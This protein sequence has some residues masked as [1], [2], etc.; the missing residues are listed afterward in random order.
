MKTNA[1]YFFGFFVTL[2]VLIGLSILSG[3]KAGKKSSSFTG[4]GDSS[5]A[6]VAGAI[7]GTLVGGSSTVGTAQLAYNYGLSAW[8]FTLGG[9]IGCL[10]MALWFVVPLRKKCSGTL[11]GLIAEEYGPRVGFAATI[12]SS[13]GIYINIIAQLI[14]STAVIAIVIPGVNSFLAALLAALLMTLYV[15]FG[16]V[17]G[18]GIVGILKTILLYVA[19]I[20]GGIIALKLFG[21]IRP[22]VDNPNFPHEQYLNLFARG[23]GKDLGAGVSL[24]LGVLSTQTYAQACLSGKSDREARKGALISAFMIP[25]IGIGGILIGMYM[26]ENC[27]D[28]VSAKMAFP[29]FVIDNMPPLLGGIVIATLLIA[30]VGTGAGLAL[31]ISTIISRDVVSGTLKKNLDEKKNLRLV[32]LTIMAVLF[33]AAFLT[34]GSLGDI[35]L[36]FSFMSM[37]LRGAVLFIP[38]MMVLFTQKKIASSYALASVTAGPA[39]VLA[40]NFIID[41]FDPLF[42]GIFVSFVIMM[43][44]YHNANKSVNLN[45]KER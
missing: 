25:P 20:G 29:Q 3:K 27:P 12:L 17:K 8:W 9:G 1:A 16:G 33:S 30:V 15:V 14:A 5:A 13:V 22:I 39:A 26:K 38:L 32:R 21:G 4:G 24:I 36:N 6:I 42:I 7:I 35:I 44:G 28:L 18:T 34:T 41:G 23:V 11:T 45:M 10:I 43:V 19:A 2:I 37:G 40:G 31:G